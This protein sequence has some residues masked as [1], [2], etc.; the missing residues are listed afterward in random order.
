M[1]SVWVRPESDGL[2]LV[3]SGRGSEI[4]SLTEES[5]E[6]VL[7]I[8]LLREGSKKK[9]RDS[10]RETAGGVKLVWTCVKGSCKENKDLGPILYC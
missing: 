8:Q 10:C 9:I 5:G 4:G 3:D 1:W 7:R 6:A 2:G